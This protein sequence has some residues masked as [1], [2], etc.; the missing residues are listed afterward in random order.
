MEMKSSMT[1]AYK[2]KIVS[3]AWKKKLR[4]ALEGYSFILPALIGM[5]VFLFIPMLTIL[6]NS[7]TDYYYLTPNDKAFIGFENY[8][9]LFDDPLFYK[10][11][12]NTL[13]FVIIVVPIQT[14][15]ALGLALL[16]HPKIKFKKFFTV[17]F[18]SP[19]V[20]SLVVVGLLFTFLYNPNQGLFNALLETFGLPRLKFLTSSDQAMNA[21]IFMSIWQG[22]GYQMIIFLAG[23]KDIPEQLYE[24]SSMD[25]ASTWQKFVYVTL[26]GLRNVTI[27]V[28]ITITMAAFRL[29]I[30]PLIMTQ[31]GPINSTKTLLYL[32]YEYG[33]QF[34]EMGYGS[35][36]AVI[37]MV[38]VL[39][40]AGIQRIVLKEER[41]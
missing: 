3:Q 4:T 7:F 25:G 34:R 8:Q 22:A 37:F 24:A 41:G 6:Y 1:A 38:I 15:V 28:V 13:Y 32:M 23:L 31:G 10:A 39:V 27:F 30:Q 33:F 18:F 16:V 40:I 17:A 9:R 5:T 29:L 14:A 26:P 19:V 20:M 36:I 2:E 35:A 12:K 21:I 11:L